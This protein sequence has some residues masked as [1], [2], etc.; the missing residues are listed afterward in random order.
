MLPSIFAIVFSEEWRISGEYSQIIL[1]LL[2][3]KFL[4]N[5]FTTTTYIYYQKQKENFMLG[6]LITVLIFVSLMIGVYYNDVKT[7]LFSMVISNGSV[8]IYKLY[9]SYK[10]VKEK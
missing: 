3:M 4:S 1:P 7:G 2:Y 8:I 6:I 9:R 5:L 10:F